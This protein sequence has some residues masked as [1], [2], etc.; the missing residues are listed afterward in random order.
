MRISSS[1]LIL[2]PTDLAHFLACRHRTALELSVAHG[3]RA[4]PKWDDPMLELL[5]EL[6]LEHERRYVA[7]LAASAA[8]LVDLGAIKDPDKAVAATLVAMRDATDVIVQAGLAVDGWYGRPDILLKVA[9][10]A[11]ALGDWSYEVA[12]T[13]L[14]RETRGGT[15]LQLGV[16]SEML[17]AAQGRTP[18]SF[19]V[20]SPA[21]PDAGEAA[22]VVR[23]YRVAH[24]AAY[25]RQLEARLGQ[26]VARGHED[27]AAAHYPEPVDHCD[28]CPWIGGCA[29]RRRQDDHL[30]LVAGISRLQRRELEPRGIAT[31]EALAAVGDPL[32]FR[33][34]RGSAD[35]YERVRDQARVQVQS[36]VA[37]H[38]VYELIPP[39][40]AAPGGPA[41]FVRLPAP[42][43]GD[44]FLDLEGDPL[45]TGGGREYLF[46]LVTTDDRVEPVYRAWWAGDAP[47]EKRAF[48]AVVDLLMARRDAYPEM[49]VYHY[50]PYEPAALKRLMG[51]HATRER[52]IDELLRGRR[53][54]DL[55]GVVRQGVRAGVERYSIKNLEPIYGFTREVPLARA[56]HALQFME[57]ALEFDR[58]E[59]ATPA[60]RAVVEGYNRDDC[61]SARRLRD[62]LEARR[63]ELVASGTPID[64][65]P[66]EPGEAPGKV[67]ERTQAVE[68][69][70]ARLLALEPAAADARPAAPS[71]ERLL[72]FLL[73]WHRRED[74]AQ[75]WEYFRLRELPEDELFD[76]P[77]AVAGLEYVGDVEAVKRSVV[78]RYRFPPQEIEIRRGDTLKRQDGRKLAEA[79]ALDRNTRT[80][81]LLVGPSKRDERPTALFAHDH[82]NARVI[83]DA[84]FALGERAAEAGGVAALD[85]CPERALLA[86]EPPRLVARPFAPPPREAGTAVT[87]Y[88]EAIVTDLDRTAL[89]IQGPPGSGKTYT[90]ARMIVALVRAGRKVGITATG[91]KVIRN[92]LDAVTKEAARSGVAIR[93]G[94]KGGDDDGAA[95]AEPPAVR[96]FDD[97]AAPLA[98][99]QAG[100]IEVLGGTAW[101]WSRAEYAASVDVLFVDEAGQMSLANVL[102]AARAAA[103]VVLLGDPQQLE[104]PS[105]G[106]HPDGVG[107]SALQHILGDAVT[108]P[109]G[110]GLFLPVTWR[111]APA[112]CAFTSEL[113]YDGQLVAREGLE[114]QVL[115]GS[116]R[117]AG[118]GLVVVPV[119]HDGNRNASDEE[120][121]AV[122]GIVTELLAPG[123]EWVDAAGAAHPCASADLRVVAP[124]NAHVTRLRDALAAAGHG[125]VPVG[126]VDRFQGQEAPVVIYSMATSRPEDAPRG[127]EF[128]YSLNRLNVATSRARCRCILVASPRLFEPECRTPRQMR[129]ANALCRYGEMSRPTNDPP[130]RPDDGRVR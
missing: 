118:A 65:P 103:S 48:E 33:P 20:V 68:A 64:R 57:Q 55:Y 127:L 41:G 128:L 81:D 51:R 47:A 114:R 28:I 15:I 129:L 73:D 42:S 101:L 80:I 30:S 24:Y 74:K 102:G 27:L 94:H 84:L 106:S 87:D 12:D 100:E 120:A 112:I 11:R 17:D 92:L 25:V 7:A 23:S 121:A 116:A 44:V 96:A 122:V 83:E 16:Y 26:A 91:H 69:L 61:V 109:E 3:A 95:S 6:G 76:E 53:F 78:Q 70:R 93:A 89:A 50:A 130:A 82:I 115:R 75:W 29:A 43:A 88:A 85:P 34:T 71:P 59:L 97:N 77:G 105:K 86:G 10:P 39:L 4:R 13:K 14:A 37:G 45:A 35:T 90:G 58:P 9:R 22:H 110:R 123:S 98:A 1:H 108:M 36:R 5:F 2:S 72:G 117:F 8:R 52:E 107:V 111:L 99:L 104:Q 54:V 119:E 18:E 46:G 40:E 113:F 66:V 19:H 56:R 21:D 31:V 126:T 60:V 67:D 32:P 49:H 38:I 125:A 63:E 62:W 79:V 124:F